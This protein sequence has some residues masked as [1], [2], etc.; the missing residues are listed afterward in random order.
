MQTAIAIK[1]HDTVVWICSWLCHT[2]LRNGKIQ[3]AVAATASQMVRV[4]EY[5]FWPQFLGYYFCAINLNTTFSFYYFWRKQWVTTF[6]LTIF[7]CESQLATFL[8]LF[9]SINIKSLLF[10][11]HYLLSHLK[12]ICFWHRKHYCFFLLYSLLFHNTV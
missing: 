8:L 5:Q 1:N 9:L 11:H 12:S 10:S 3:R 2:T 7:L 4:Q 6:L